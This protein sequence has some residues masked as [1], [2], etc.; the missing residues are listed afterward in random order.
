MLVYP[1]A[2]MAAAGAPA[3]LPAVPLTPVAPDTAQITLPVAV[4]PSEPPPDILTVGS[5]ELFGAQPARYMSS[6]QIAAPTTIRYKKVE[7]SFAPDDRFIEYR[8]AIRDDVFTVYCTARPSKPV[9]MLLCLADRDKDGAFEQLWL[10]STAHPRLWVPFPDIRFQTAIDPVRYATTED[11]AGDP[12][13]IGFGGSGGNIWTGRR[14]FF[15]KI[16]KGQDQVLLFESRATGSA[17]RGPADIKLY[18]AV[19][20]LHG[21][22]RERLEVSVVKG[23]TAGRYELSVNYPTQQIWITIP[24]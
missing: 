6:A 5:L 19:V 7:L 3:G 17:R 13:S 8:A 22:T 1:L 10:G 4:T 14:E 2:L 21:G 16:A 15:V 9:S 18:D 20:R 23:L 12:L 11:T 24:G